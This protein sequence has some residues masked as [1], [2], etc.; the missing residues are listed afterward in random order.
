[1]ATKTVAPSRPHRQEEIDTLTREVQDAVHEGV[2]DIRETLGS[3]FE[4]IQGMVNDLSESIHESLGVSHDSANGPDSL[5]ERLDRL[6]QMLEGWQ[7]ANETQYKDAAF[8]AFLKAPFPF[9]NEVSLAILMGNIELLPRG[10]DLEKA[11]K[12]ERAVAF[13]KVSR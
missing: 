3:E 6:E 4:C 7:W 1:M 12:S 2:E 13:T 8:Q 10:F 5:A 9:G 11:S